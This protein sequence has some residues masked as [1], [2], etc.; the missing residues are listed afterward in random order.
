MI[1]EYL[2]C[3][4]SMRGVPCPHDYRGLGNYDSLINTWCWLQT[5]DSGWLTSGDGFNPLLPGKRKTDRQSS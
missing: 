2:S 1:T 3:P 4:L 5:G